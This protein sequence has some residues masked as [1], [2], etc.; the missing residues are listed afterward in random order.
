MAYFT[1][2]VYQ[3]KAEWAARKMHEQS[4]I[5]TLTEEQHDTLTWLC[6]YRHEFHCNYEHLFISDQSDM[7]EYNPDEIN[8]RLLECNLPAIEGL[9]DPGD[10]PWDLDFDLLSH[11]E[12]EDWE[13]KAAE[14][15]SSGHHK[16]S[17]SG[18]TLW[19]EDSGVYDEFCEI[20][21]KINDTIEDY[22]A[23]VDC[24]YGTE[25]CPTQN[26]RMAELLGGTTHNDSHTET[27]NN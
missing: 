14:F 5:K 23:Q 26:A 12:Q 15:N 8:K 20:M 18:F 19:K 16:F 13:R 7:C 1:K 9:P 6:D 25:Y 11:E 21:E 3:R 4:K 10:L 24:F 27:M 2:E 22:L 17:H